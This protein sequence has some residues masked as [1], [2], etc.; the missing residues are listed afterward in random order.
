M[1]IEILAV[2]TRGDVQP[3]VALGKGLLAA[4]HCV[5]LCTC[6][7]FESFITDHGLN[8]ASMNDD[9]ID[10]M[11]SDDGKIAMENTGNWWEAIKTAFKLL[12]KLGPMQ[13]QQIKDTW[14]STCAAKPDLILFH[15]KAVGAVD[16]A[17][18]LGVPCMLA[19]YLPMYVSTG[20]F[21]AMGI[22]DLRIGR[23][24]NRLTYRF[25]A[26][27]TWWG[28]G[29]YINE[30][31]QANGLPPR[32][33]GKYL[34]H[35]NGEPIPALHAYSESIIP[36]PSD[37]PESATVT[38]YW[39]LNHPEGWRPSPELEDFL[40]GGE[41]PVYFGFGSIFGR[42][43]VHL[44]QIV[45]DAVRA[46][47]VRAIIASGWGG[48]D[49]ARFEL[50]STVLAIDSVPH[51][52]LFPRVAAV[53]HHGGCGTTA[54]G[55]RAG[56]PTVVCSFFGDQPFWGAKVKALGV[57]PAAIPQKRLSVERLS[58]AI[59]QAT[60]DVTLREKAD[61]LGQRIRNEDGV[62]N[63]VQFINHWMK[64]SR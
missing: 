35:A 54:A 27:A 60:T 2:G 32:R 62:G 3:Y 46:T 20:S 26:K 21:P 43:P 7:K 42:D 55:L 57:G 30:W 17:E 15:P 28:T 5:T 19:F 48:L 22:P 50:P 59:T 49:P 45:L 31:R 53:V 40:A 39:F 14:E 9:L 1:N 52:W 33:G 13:R 38:G 37:W 51:D 36:R 47:G 8:Y 12:P 16:F 29:K 44:T 64:R 18:R 10:F 24:Y 56:R 6:A 25:I 58:A 23:W 4:G 41:P 34:R 11:H 63:A 61:A